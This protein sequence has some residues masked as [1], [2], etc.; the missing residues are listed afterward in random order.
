VS[1]YFEKLCERIIESSCSVLF[2]NQFNLAEMIH[3]FGFQ[4]T[5]F[6]AWQTCSL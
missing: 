5:D 4:L 6:W 2:V 3:S 1:C